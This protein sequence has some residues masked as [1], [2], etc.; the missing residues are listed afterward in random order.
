MKCIALKAAFLLLLLQK[1]H[2]RSK[3]NEHV[4]ALEPRIVLWKDR[5]FK[6]LLKEGNT[7]QKKFKSNCCHKNKSDPLRLFTHFMF[8]GNVKGALHVLNENGSRT[9]QLLSL[10]SHLRVISFFEICS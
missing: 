10:S 1:P 9:G 7:I 6:D 2:R 3:L 4:K 8:Q 5:L